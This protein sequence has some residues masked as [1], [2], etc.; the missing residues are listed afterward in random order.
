MNKKEK[1]ELRRLLKKAAADIIVSVTRMIIKVV[2]T[3]FAPSVMLFIA[4]GLTVLR[5]ENGNIEGIPF[6]L[7]IT[8]AMVWLKTNIQH[9]WQG[10]PWG[11]TLLFGDKEYQEYEDEYTSSHSYKPL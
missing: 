3:V 10:K 5:D 2:K 7:C 6:L 8:F 9:Y 11:E 4:W 1:I